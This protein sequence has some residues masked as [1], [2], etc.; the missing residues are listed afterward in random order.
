MRRILSTAAAALAMGAL[1]A[2]PAQAAPDQAADAQRT[3]S[4]LCPA[5]FRVDT[6]IRELP[7]ATSP[8][9]A[10]VPAGE[11]A[12][13]AWCVPFTPGGNHKTCGFSSEVWVAV[14]WD[15]TWGFAHTGCM[16]DYYLH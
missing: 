15:G 14:R 1:W 13:G 4:V 3:E 2:V 10:E 16:D 12:D 7:Y 5:K 8:V 6:A 11:W 9:I